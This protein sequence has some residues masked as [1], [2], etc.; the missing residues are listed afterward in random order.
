MRG[1]CV[2]VV[3]HSRTSMIT[4]MRS[5]FSAIRMSCLR[6]SR[7]AFAL[8]IRTCPSRIAWIDAAATG[9]AI[10]A[11]VKSRSSRAATLPLIEAH[12]LLLFCRG[13]PL[14]AARDVEKSRRSPKPF[15][16][17]SCFG[18]GIEDLIDRRAGGVKDFRGIFEASEIL[19][20]HFKS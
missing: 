20:M 19:Y 4:H 10:C 16:S 3:V 15:R 14:C 13:T 8:T 6:L 1:P 12:C 17:S 2:A 18:G 11:S 7:S 9:E 5:S